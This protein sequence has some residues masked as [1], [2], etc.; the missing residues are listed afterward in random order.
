MRCGGHVMVASLS[1][2][3]KDPQCV[4]ME[5]PPSWMLVQ[6]LVT[7]GRK[8]LWCGPQHEQMETIHTLANSYTYK[9]LFPNGSGLFQ[10]DSAPCHTAKMVLKWFEEHNNVFKVLTCRPD[11][12]VLSLIEHLW[13]ELDKKV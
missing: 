8:K 11:S 1:V 7:F 6:L 5:S 2:W 4:V 13:D 9:A 3:L 10:Q 12:P